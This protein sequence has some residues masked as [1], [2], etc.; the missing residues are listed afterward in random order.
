MSQP[1]PALKGAD[2]LLANARSLARPFYRKTTATGRAR[3][4]DLAML[5]GRAP[6]RVEPNGTQWARILRRSRSDLRD[7]P[8][9]SGPRVLIATVYGHSQAML[10]L[11]SI[12]AMGL[13]L[14]GASPSLLRCD[15]HLPAC[16][17]NRFGNGD[18]APGAFAPPQ[19]ERT[20]LD[21]C[22]DCNGAIDDTFQALPIPNVTLRDHAKPGDLERA[23]KLV[24]ST[25]FEEYRALKHQ[26][27]AVGDHAY[28]SVMRATLR[29]TMIDDE[30]TRFLFRRYL[31]ASIL[32]TDL[33]HRV[34]DSVRPDRFV[35]HHGIYVTHGTATEIARQRGIPVVVHGFPPRGG[36][37]I[38][39]HG[40]TYHRTLVSE[41]N[42]DWESAPLNE[43]QAKIV[44]DYVASKRFGG[45]DYISYHVNAV[46]DFD[47]LVRDLG[48]DAK[49]PIVS[50]FTNVLWDAQLYYQYNA[51]P[52][53][54][55]WLWETVRYFERRPEVQL[56]IRIHP[57]EAKGAMPTAQPLLAEIEREFPKLAQ[58]V[59]VI[60]A[61]SDLSSYTLA[62]HSCASLIYGARMGMEIALAGTPLIVAGE[63]FNRGKGYSYDVETPREYFD[64]L[65]KLPG[66]PRN[67]PEMMERARRYAYHMYFRRM[68]DFP[69]LSVKNGQYMTGIRLAFRRVRD[70]GPGQSGAMDA[71]CD[72][73][74][75]GKPFVHDPAAQGGPTMPS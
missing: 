13:R 12:L 70:L 63:T 19:T 58:N 74:L 4:N 28:S 55:D 22:R 62:E 24:D 68:I 6:E 32:M 71:L 27:V 17:W 44:D 64:L 45:R 66:L 26:G 25:P 52:S 39:S 2:A 11:E 30:E 31:L 53:M 75:E 56:V 54:L 34:F 18:P 36:T 16:E 65:D 59:K 33:T 57:A 51:F 43:A 8:P 5:L 61:E 29:G 1:D 41:S 67:P 15:S 14:R 21:A 7:L 49:L 42:A 38:F 46:S 60:P 9:A 37:V 48:L 40:D 73:I 50:L 47:A 3:A 69:F 35:V 23:V 20:R 72:G 10:A